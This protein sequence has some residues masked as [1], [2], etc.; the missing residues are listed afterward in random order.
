M[1]HKHEKTHIE[2]IETEYSGDCRTEVG[3]D[4]ERFIKR[5]RCPVIRWILSEDLMYMAYRDYIWN[6]IRVN[7]FEA[8]LSISTPPPNITM[9][10][11]GCIN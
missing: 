6:V 9:W 2:L 7:G 4:E 1:E 3:G 11:D 5:C 8:F 10:G